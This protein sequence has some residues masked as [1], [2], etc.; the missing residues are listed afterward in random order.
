MNAAATPFMEHG[1]DTTSSFEGTLDFETDYVYVET[2]SM[3]HENF[4]T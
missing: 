2:L 1:N 4:F 3:I